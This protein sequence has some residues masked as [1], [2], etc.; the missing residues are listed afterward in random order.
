MQCQRYVTTYQNK[1]DV[2]LAAKEKTVIAFG[3]WMEIQIVLYVRL[4]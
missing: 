3:S 1:H 4:I 2:W